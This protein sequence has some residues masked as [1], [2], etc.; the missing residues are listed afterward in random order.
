MPDNTP[1]GRRSKV[2]GI[3][4]DGFHKQNEWAHHRSKRPDR[5]DIVSGC[6]QLPGDEVRMSSSYVPGLLRPHAVREYNVGK[7]FETEPQAPQALS[8]ICVSFSRYRIDKLGEAGG[9][10]LHGILVCLP[11]RA[12]FRFEQG[13]SEAVRAI[14]EDMRSIRMKISL[15]HW[16]G[17]IT[18]QGPKSSTSKGIGAVPAPI[19]PDPAQAA[20]AGCVCSCRRLIA[21]PW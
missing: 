14:A 9:R 21:V 13:Q 7:L 4:Q 11:Q 20:T 16:G 12:R 5:A 8:G 15:Q 19:D 3:L 1:Y 10:V 2:M 18:A 6:M 17:T